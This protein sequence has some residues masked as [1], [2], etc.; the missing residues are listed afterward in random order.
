VINLK[1]VGATKCNV[2]FGCSQQDT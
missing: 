2:E 1:L